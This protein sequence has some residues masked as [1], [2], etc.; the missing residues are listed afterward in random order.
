MRV[1]KRPKVGRMTAEC[2]EN[3]LSWRVIA[4]RSEGVH[5][6][7]VASVGDNPE[8]HILE[9]VWILESWLETI[10]EGIRLRETGE[11]VWWRPVVLRLRG[12]SRGPSRG[13][14]G[15]WRCRGSGKCRIPVIGSHSKS[16]GRSGSH[17]PG[18]SRDPRTPSVRSPG[19]SRGSGGSG[20]P[21][22]PR[23]SRG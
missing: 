6:T 22:D 19:K 10:L 5:T 2:G 17:D 13:W 16:R 23:N 18:K 11:S 7:T 21:R 3:E 14:S 12:D 20:N 15:S 4:T 8:G 1:M 9:A